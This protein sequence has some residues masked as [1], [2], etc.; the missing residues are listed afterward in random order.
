[1]LRGRLRRRLSPRAPPPAEPTSAARPPSCPARTQPVLRPALRRPP[2]RRGCQRPRADR[3]HHFV[4]HLAPP[5]LCLAFIAANVA[6]RASCAGADA[7]YTARA[8]DERVGVKIS[9]WE[10]VEKKPP[11]LTCVRTQFDHFLYFNSTVGF[12]QLQGGVLSS[13]RFHPKPAGAH[14]SAPLLV[15]LQEDEAMIIA[16]RVSCLD[17]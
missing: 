8:P 9:K 7:R 14:T 12:D 13:D 4:R 11:N 2:L 6:G 10:A 15:R 5:P 3:L 16:H 1:M 17:F